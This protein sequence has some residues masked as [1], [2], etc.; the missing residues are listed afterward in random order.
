MTCHDNPIKKCFGKFVIVVLFHLQQNFRKTEI[1]GEH[2]T[3]NLQLLDV[4]QDGIN[5]FKT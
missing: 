1:V 2:F 5:T 4:D 3:E